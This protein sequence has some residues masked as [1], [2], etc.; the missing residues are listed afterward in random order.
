MILGDYSGG[1][2][3]VPFPNTEV[4]PSYADDTALLKGGKVG[5]RQVFFLLLLLPLAR[6]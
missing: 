5:H 3:P 4:K 1:V 2:T 6:F